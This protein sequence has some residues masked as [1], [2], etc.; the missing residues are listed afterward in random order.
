MRGRTST[1][2]AGQPSGLATTAHGTS[3]T[4]DEKELSGNIVDVITTWN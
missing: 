2:Q 1:P 4:C 3:S